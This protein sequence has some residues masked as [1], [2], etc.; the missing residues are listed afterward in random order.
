[1]QAFATDASPPSTPTGHALQ[2][3]EDQPLR[4]SQ[5]HAHTSTAQPSQSKPGPRLA[6]VAGA[7]AATSSATAL[8]MASASSLR[9]AQRTVCAARKQRRGPEALIR[10]WKARGALH[11]LLLDAPA[12]CH[13]RSTE[14]AIVSPILSN[15]KLD[16]SDLVHCEHACFFV[17]QKV[18]V[19]EA[20]SPIARTWVS[21]SRWRFPVGGLAA[22][23][24]PRGRLGA[25][26]RGL[27]RLH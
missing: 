5:Q 25:T 21:R 13:G 27:I 9:E 4:R 11:V 12:D 2:I 6:T 19:S 24:G 10:P 26:H 14:A 20:E 23:N 8:R 15:V 22:R 18:I 1:M 17:C 16:A 7:L 3:N